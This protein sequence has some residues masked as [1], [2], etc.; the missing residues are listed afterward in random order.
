MNYLKRKVS[1]EEWNSICMELEDYHSV[2]YQVWK[3]GRP[4]FTDSIPTAAVSFDK[5][6]NFVLFLFNPEYWDKL[7]AYSKKFVIC[8]EVLHV[9][10]N[11]GIRT[12]DCATVN[13]AAT[14]AAL[15][16]VVN[17]SL[18]NS[19]GFEREKV[20][21]QAELC[22]IDTVFKN[23]KSPIEHRQCY[24]YYYNKFEKIYGDGTWRL[25]KEGENPDGTL[26]S[27][28]YMSPKHSDDWQEFIEKLN[29]EMNDEEKDQIKKFLE[30]N[31]EKD[32]NKKDPET[33]KKAGSGVG[34]WT[35]VNI[36]EKIK[37]KK[38]WETIIKKWSL[39]VRQDDHREVEQWARDHRRLTALDLDVLIPSEM[40]VE[41]LEFDVH[42]TRVFFFLDTSG[43]CYNLKDRFFEAAL[44]L[45]EKKF[46][47]RL[48]CFDTAIEET[49]LKSRQIYGGGGTSFS[50][51]EERVQAEIQ[52]AGLKEHPS[53]WVLT[54]G[55]GDKIDPSVPNQWHWFITEGGNTS[56]INQN[57]NFYELRNFE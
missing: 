37:K 33:S 19:F 40:E 57:C 27:H 5:V 31:Y 12:V 49:T 42:K 38:K 32:P 16:I 53:V 29:A 39:K 54:D 6:G 21:N 52:K 41:D 10:L 24:E 9:I 50:I 45:D 56:L 25:A 51:I 17:H 36:S 20:H 15:D 44:S 4:I 43:S 13:R 3:M 22:W 46:E 26:D 8:H 35:F 47:V 30:K 14:N 23:P 7:D 34:G 2:F 18:V 48:F 1:V 55:Y 11:H 28:E